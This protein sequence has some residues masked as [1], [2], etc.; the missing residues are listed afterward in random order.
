MVGDKYELGDHHL[1]SNLRRVRV[2]RFV[3]HHHYTK[4]RP[5]EESARVLGSAKIWGSAKVG[6]SMFIDERHRK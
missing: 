5:G 2:Q 4:I 1:R 3:G 6:G